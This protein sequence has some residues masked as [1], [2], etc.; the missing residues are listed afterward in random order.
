MEN[1]HCKTSQEVADFFGTDLEKGLSPEQ[2]KRLFE[3]Y[4]PN[5]KSLCSLL[6]HHCV[7]LT[8]SVYPDRAS[9]RRGQIDLAVGVGTVR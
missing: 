1:G 4:G 5:G 9:G 6:S 2:V 3:K 7:V 8:L